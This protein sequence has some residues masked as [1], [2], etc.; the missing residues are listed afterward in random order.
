MD[1]NSNTNTAPS[2]DKL[3]CAE[4]REKY[5]V[6]L[7]KLPTGSHIECTSIKIT[8]DNWDKVPKMYEYRQYLYSLYGQDVSIIYEQ[9][10]GRG[11]VIVFE[12]YTAEN[13]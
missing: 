10:S 2:N 1:E 7:G 9:L 3:T 13:S 6:S 11:D 8:V 5:R 4:F 12:W